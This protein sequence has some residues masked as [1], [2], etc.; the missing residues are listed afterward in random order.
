[1]TVGSWI[2]NCERIW[3][4]EGLGALCRRAAAKVSQFLWQ[5]NSADWYCVGL[6]SE[7]PGL[8]QRPAENLEIS[9]DCTEA[10]IEWMR[11]LKQQFGF[12]YVEEEVAAARQHGHVYA[13][14]R[15]DGQRAG[16]IK[17]G[18]EKAYVGDLGRKMLLPADAGFVYDTFV[19]PD[20]RGR[21][22]APHLVAKAMECAALRGCRSL[23]CHIP[24]WNIQSIRS[25]AR[26]GFQRRGYIVN[27]RLVRWRFS[28][29]SPEKLMALRE[30]VPRRG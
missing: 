2:E 22:L 23:W 12:A 24:R 16:Y 17:L 6:P 28:T 25:F 4:T 11:L 21:H 14:A 1:L 20:Y 19:H 18:L 7:P 10:A 29:R 27:F 8:A 15:L 26:C 9:L 5:S 3:L 30:P 13:L